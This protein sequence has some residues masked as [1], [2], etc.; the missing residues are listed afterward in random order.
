MSGVRDSATANILCPAPSC[1]YTFVDARS[2]KKHVKKV[3]TLPTAIV[4]KGEMEP[5][6]QETAL[7][8]IY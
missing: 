6:D 7:G 1:Q 2:F 3:H 5:S 8:F 4:N